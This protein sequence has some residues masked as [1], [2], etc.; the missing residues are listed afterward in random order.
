MDLA[1]RSFLTP[2]VLLSD[3][4]PTLVSVT[5]YNMQIGANSYELQDSL[6]AAF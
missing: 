2:R 4:P 1:L 5:A 6:A 3:R